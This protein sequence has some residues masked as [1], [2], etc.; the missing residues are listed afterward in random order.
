MSALFKAALPNKKLENTPFGLS[1]MRVAVGELRD[2]HYGWGGVVA[3]PSG[4]WVFI[5]RRGATHGVSDNAELRAADSYDLGATWAN[6]RLLYQDPTH[7]ARPDPPRLMANNR[8][9]FFVNRQDEGSTHFS[10]LFFKS[11]DEGVTFSSSVITTSSPYTFAAAN[12]GILDFPASQGG[13]DTLGFISYGYL[14]AT[15]LDAFTTINNGDTWSTVTEVAQADG[16]LLTSISENFGVRIGTQDKWIFFCRCNSPTS[17]PEMVVYVT[18]DMLDWGTPVL[19]GVELNR[20]SP[21]ALYDSATNKIHLLSNARG[22]RDINGFENHLLHIEVDADDLYG[23]NGDFASLGLSYSIL[24]PVPH[25]ATGYIA[26][27]KYGGRWFATFTCGETGEAGGELALQILI[28]DF[29]P[30]CADTMKLVQVFMRHQKDV[31]FLEVIANDNVITNY[32]LTLSN[33]SKTATASYGAYG[34]SIV[35]GG[36]NYDFS[37]DNNM[38]FGV[39][40]GLTFEVDGDVLFD[41]VDTILGL[42]AKVPGVAS[43]TLHLGVQGA[44]YPAAASYNAG[45]SSRKHYVFHNENGEVGSISTSG[46][47]TSFTTS[48]DETWKNF[49]GE[50]SPLSAINIIK[51]DPV[52]EFNWKPERG[53]GYAV[54]WGAQTSYAVSSDLASKGGWFKDDTECAP[55]TE[56]AVYVPWGVDQSKR[57]PYL[58]AAVS[59]LID[60]LVETEGRL[61]ALEA[62]G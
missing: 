48:S 8:V 27:F 15:G 38:T 19:A 7:D 28:G 31:H 50:Y 41:V 30:T 34:T 42:T 33:A 56:G 5:Y 43:A 21:C 14:S 4:K 57:T 54:G 24:T 29:I 35:T 32:P 62:G 2:A 20:N 40:G 3:F 49:I 26:P 22:N 37:V 44:S 53:G 61:A 51:A 25:W 11:D 6:D 16:V 23:A 39:S 52:R 18:T 47:A 60:K 46:T 9:G 59:H 45:S 1:G 10:P 55:D 58:W 17:D 13:S 12:G 36:S